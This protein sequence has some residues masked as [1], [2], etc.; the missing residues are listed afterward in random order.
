VSD[1]LRNQ[2]AA[3]YGPIGP[4]PY[5][6]TFNGTAAGAG[7]GLIFSGPGTT[8]TASYFRQPSIM[9]P[10]DKIMLAEEPDDDA[11]RPPGNTRTE[12]ED[13]RWLPKAPNNGTWNGKTVGLR[14]SKSTG[15]VNFA[16]GHAQS[17]PWQWTS[18][19]Y[20]FDPTNN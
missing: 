7:M 18:N 9:R 10:A 16:D 14:H 11:E 8:A 3:E 6:Y 13:G 19:T 12:L 5:S 4:F 1:E 17:I 2:A 20:Y 15:N